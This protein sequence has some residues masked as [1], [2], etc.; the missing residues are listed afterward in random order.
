MPVGRG[1]LAGIVKICGLTNPVDAAAAAAAGADLVGFVFFAGSRRALPAGAVEWVAA[2]PRTP[3]KVGVFR[4][5]PSGF[6]EEV[7]SRAGLARVQLHGAEPPEM[8]AALGGRARV[9]KAVSVSGPL[10]WG[11]VRAWAEVAQ[12]LFDTAS[13]TGGGTGRV[14][15]WGW[16]AQRPADLAVWLA[17]GL[18]PANVT[19]AIAA[20][21]PAGV[22]VASGVEAAVGRKDLASMRAF[23]AAARAAWAALGGSPKGGAR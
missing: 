17:G 16:L 13:P 14:F 20:V 9:I 21:R 11:Q 7:A 15:D 22:D 3:A 6:V 10:D 12:I 2:L 23:V 8:C 19:A 18:T 4:D 5:Q 1:G